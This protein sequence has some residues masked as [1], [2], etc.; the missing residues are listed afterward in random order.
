VKRYVRKFAPADVPQLLRRI[1]EATK[2]VT[3][4]MIEGW[5]KKAGFR[6]PREAETEPPQPL[7][8]EV[9][10]CHLPATTRFDRKE[11]IVC[12]DGEGAVRREKKAQHVK[13]SRYDRDVKEEELRDVSVVKTK[14]EPRPPQRPCSP[15]V[16][17]GKARWVGLTP[18]PPGL[19]HRNFD[20]L[21]DSEAF[22]EVERIVQERKAKNQ[23]EYLIRWKGFGPEHD[24]WVKEKDIMGLGEL[25]RYWREER[26][27]K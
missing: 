22:A 2:K 12:M 4:D 8:K 14:K 23:A 10:R 20:D 15:P 13:W 19:E 26:K 3:G 1:R 16:D 18:E 17:G 11:H 7:E 27:R 5:F 25:L 6:C 24:T 21:F 9:N